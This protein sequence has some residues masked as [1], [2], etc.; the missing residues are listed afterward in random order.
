MTRIMRFDH[1]TTA[2]TPLPNQL[3]M[4]GARLNYGM[5]IFVLRVNINKINIQ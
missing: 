4:K 2:T 5:I 3:L 1:I